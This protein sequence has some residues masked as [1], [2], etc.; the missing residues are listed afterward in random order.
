MNSKKV[1]PFGGKRNNSLYY[2]QIHKSVPTV[3][4]CALLGMGL[5]ILYIITN[6]NKVCPFAPHLGGR[7]GETGEK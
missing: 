2:R 7:K 5:L 3:P 4:K 1:C 6:Y